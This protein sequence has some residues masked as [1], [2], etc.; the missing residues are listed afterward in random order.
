VSA[1]P[2]SRRRRLTFFSVAIINAVNFY[3]D[4]PNVV[5]KLWASDAKDIAVEDCIYKALRKHGYSSVL[6]IL[7]SF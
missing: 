1:V 4:Q 7:M 2:L 3:L 6:R 5:S